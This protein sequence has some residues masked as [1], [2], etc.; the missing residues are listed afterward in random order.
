MNVKGVKVKNNKKQRKYILNIEMKRYQQAKT[1][2]QRKII[3]R[4]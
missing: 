3:N 2:K 4:K 1:I